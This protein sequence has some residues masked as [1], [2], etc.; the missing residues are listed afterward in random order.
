METATRGEAEEARRNEGSGREDGR[1]ARNTFGP[2]PRELPPRPRRVD[3][4]ESGH[5]P[6]G[7]GRSPDLASDGRTEGGA[8]G[9]ICI[10]R[11]RPLSVSMEALGRWTP[12][13]RTGRSGS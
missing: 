10:W 7:Y 13:C 1:K 12:N 4:A 11:S 2:C 6:A 9:T 8:I 5:L 3:S